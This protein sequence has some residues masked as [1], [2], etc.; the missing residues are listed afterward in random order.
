MK[1]LKHLCYLCYENSGDEVDATRQ[2]FAETAQEWYEIC[3]SCFE[4]I[5]K[6]GLKTKR[7]TTV[8]EV[9]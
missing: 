9:E 3:D 2:Y 1:I 8:E 6:Q 7:I 5:K 4:L